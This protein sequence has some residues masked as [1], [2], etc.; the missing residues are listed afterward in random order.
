MLQYYTIACWELAQLAQK[1]RM[2]FK[3]VRKILVNKNANTHFSS[4]EFINLIGLI[5]IFLH[6][7]YL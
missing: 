7:L 2:F 4:L 1:Q 3:K 6:Q 5:S